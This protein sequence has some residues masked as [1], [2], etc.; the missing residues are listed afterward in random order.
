MQYIPLNT[1]LSDWTRD[2]GRKDEIDEDAILQWSSDFIQMMGTH[3]QYRFNVAVINIE[4]F[5]GSLPK[6]FQ[7]VDT[8]LFNPSSACN[9]NYTMKLS[10]II[11]P[12]YGE[13]CNV[14]V[15]QECDDG[16]CGIVTV[17]A[18]EDIKNNYPWMGYSRI[19]TTSDDFS[20]GMFSGFFAIKTSDRASVNKHLSDSCNIGI[21][22]SNISYKLEGQSIITSVKSGTVVL[23]YLGSVVDDEGYPMIPDNIWYI[24]ALTLY[25]E[26]MFAFRDYTASKSA[27]ARNFFADVNQLYNRAFED[28]KLKLNTPTWEEAKEIDSIIRQRI[29]STSLGGSRLDYY[30]IKQRFNAGTGKYN[31]SRRYK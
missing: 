21:V 14:K 6:D 29:P 24:K 12:M 18:T 28:C 15:T 13:T 31:R 16:C 20:Q 7:Y 3:K 1:I 19:V 23:F 4:N 26:R 17:D 8:V 10:E 11:Y 2:T 5:K 27:E 9:N 22:D 25:I 30:Q